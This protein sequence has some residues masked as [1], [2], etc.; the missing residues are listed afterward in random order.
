MTSSLILPHLLSSGCKWPYSF[1]SLF[2][3]SEAHLLYENYVILKCFVYCEDYINGYL[4]YSTHTSPNTH[5]TQHTPLLTQ[6]APLLTQHTGVHP[7]WAGRV[8]CCFSVQGFSS[9][10]TSFN[11]YWPGRVQLIFSVDLSFKS[12]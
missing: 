10:L 1:Y 6:H 9:H 5:L 11:P 7:L 12:K 4:P 3:C 8:Q 2:A